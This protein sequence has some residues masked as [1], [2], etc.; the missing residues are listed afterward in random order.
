[1]IYWTGNIWLLQKFPLEKIL[2]V[3][4]FVLYKLKYWSWSRGKVSDVYPISLATDQK[5]KVI[6]ASC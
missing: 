5:E 3:Y 2:T 4:H 6:F 1:M